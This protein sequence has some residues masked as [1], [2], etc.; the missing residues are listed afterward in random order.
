M[1]K[2]NSRLMVLIS[3]W[4]VTLW[5]SAAA[6]ETYRIVRIETTAVTAHLKCTVATVQF[7]ANPL[8][9][10]LIHRVA[11]N[12]PSES[13]RGSILLLP[14]LG[15]GFQNYE[16]GENNDYNNSFVAFFAQRGFAVWGYSQRVQGLAA[17]ACESGSVDCAPMA[18]WGL[19]TI[20]DDVAFI[21]DH[22]QRLEQPILA[23]LEGVV[24]R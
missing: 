7:G 16:V 6:T 22:R 19:Q 2:M 17:G 20:V 12:A 10:F 4:L 13:L 24:A 21:V 14:P 1:F 5:T 9:R 23:W 8:N 18:D 3:L 15:S 11:K